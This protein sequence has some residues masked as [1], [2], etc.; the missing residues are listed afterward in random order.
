MI[1]D[2]LF[3]L[4]PLPVLE[5]V[6]R[7]NQLAYTCSCSGTDKLSSALRTRKRTKHSPPSTILRHTEDYSP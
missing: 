7:R 6:Y 3:L 5:M 2:F 1:L 4:L